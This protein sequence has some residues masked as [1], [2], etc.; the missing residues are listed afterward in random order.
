M[1]KFTLFSL[2]AAAILMTAG[3]SEPEETQ[4]VEVIKGSEHLGRGYDAS[5]HYASE[6]DIKSPVLDLSSLSKFVDIQKPLVTQTYTTYGSDL[7]S[8]VDKMVQKC[9]LDGKGWGFTA[10]V[11]ESFTENTSTTLENSFY[12]SRHTKEMV[13]YR[14]FS[15]VTLEQMKSWRSATFLNNIQNKTAESL[16]N[17]YGTHVVTGYVLGGTIEISLTALKSSISSV[18]DFEFMAKMG[19]QNAIGKVGGSAELELAKYNEMVSKAENYSQKIIYRGGASGSVS[20]QGQDT[21][22]AEWDRSLEDPKYQIMVEFT[23]DGLLP[24]SLFV[25]DPALAKEIDAVIAKKMKQIE[26][27]SGYMPV[28]VYLRRI[29]SSGYWDSNGFCKWKFTTGAKLNQPNRPGQEQI[30]YMMDTYGKHGDR[31]LPDDYLITD[32]KNSDW[33]GSIPY[34][35]FKEGVIGAHGTDNQKAAISRGEP[36]TQ[37][38]KVHSWDAN[39]LTVFVNDLIQYNAGSSN[40]DMGSLNVALSFNQADSTWTYNDSGNNPVKVYDRN[41]RGKNHDIT[42]TGYSNKSNHRGEYV[43]F[44]FEYEWKSGGK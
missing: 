20:E 21:K 5:E 10:S 15:E 17:M 32:A 8:Y 23:K 38:L 34:I 44:I 18:Q 14:L 24:L 31:F 2:F 4:P 40:D 42:I 39:T 28:Q 12:T 43:K 36:R 6:V 3:C 13:V 7:T 35:D 9:V 22:Y 25:D 37:E 27:K 41:V 30:G 11:K 29:D 33:T 16:V 19:Y 26:Q 1:K